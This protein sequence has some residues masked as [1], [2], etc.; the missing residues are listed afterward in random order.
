[1]TTIEARY[2]RKIQLEQFEPIEHGVVLVRDVPEDEDVDEAYDDL[3][4]K[5]EDMVERQ[6]AKRV[7]QQK[8][9]DSDD[10]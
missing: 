5:A 6:L 1:M 4:E 7:A 3:A 2:T 9:A 8:L 10:E